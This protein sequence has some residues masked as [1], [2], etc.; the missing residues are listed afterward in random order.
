MPVVVPFF[1]GAKQLTIELAE[2]VVILRGSPADNITHVLQGEV[3]VVLTRPVSI[4]QV[5]V[6][7]IGKT[8][9]L[10]PEGIILV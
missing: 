5:V 3:S 4:S 6:Q 7:F 8:T 1:T 2:P 10:W 9:R